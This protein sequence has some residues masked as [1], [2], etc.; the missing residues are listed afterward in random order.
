MMNAHEIIN[1]NE[2][3]RSLIFAFL[4]FLLM[5]PYFVWHK[6]HPLIFIS[7]C[8]VLSFQNIKLNSVPKA[9]FV[10]FLTIFYVYLGFRSG[11]N[12]FGFMPLF[13]IVLLVLVE[14]KFLIAALK[15]FILIYSIS[16]I[17]SILSY[18][19]VNVFSVKLPY[20]IIKPINLLKTY[21]YIKYPFYVQDNKLISLFLPRF[22]AYFDEPGVVGTF[23]GVL[24]LLDGFNLRKKVN[25]PIIIAGLL[26]FSFA[27]YIMLLGYFLMFVKTKYK[28][29][30]LIVIIALFPV[31]SNNEVLNGYIL[32][33]FEIQEDGTLAGDN[34]TSVK[35]DDFYERFS[36]SDDFYFGLGKE[37]KLKYNYSGAS[38]KD[39]IVNYGIIPFIAFML[40]FILYAFN[41]IKFKKEFFIYIVILASVIYQRP[42]IMNY[43]YVCLIFVPIVLLSAKSN[44]NHES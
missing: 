22:H 13:G 8:V 16:L 23:S 42:F 20:E 19:L 36:N 14:D 15:Y 37:A 17:P 29:I 6:I 40:I 44:Y 21:D 34:R 35:L 4:L 5:P 1:R 43:I 25:I 41:K 28:I 7:L 30:G 11:Q 33:R 31:I 26:S 38:Y 2:R 3:I 9:V 10:F 27:F 32:S 18:L 12:F 24:L 39:L